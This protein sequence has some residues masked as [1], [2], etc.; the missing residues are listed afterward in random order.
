LLLLRNTAKLVSPI[1]KHNYEEANSAGAVC[2][3]I[4]W[5]VGAGW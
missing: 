4:V 2:N 3:S 1:N 5:R